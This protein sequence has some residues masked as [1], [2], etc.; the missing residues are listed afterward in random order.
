MSLTRLGASGIVP[1]AKGVFITRPLKKFTPVEITPNPNAVAPPYLENLLSAQHHIITL[2][3]FLALRHQFSS[4]LYFNVATAHGWYLLAPSSFSPLADAAGLQAWR[5]R[6][7]HR[8]LPTSRKGRRRKASQLPSKD[9]ATDFATPISE[10]VEAHTSNTF[11]EEGEDENVDNGCALRTNGPQAGHSM[12]LVTQSP[13]SISEDHL[14]EI[15]DGVMWETP[16]DD[17]LASPEYWKGH[18]ERMQVYEET[19]VNAEQEQFLSMSDSVG[20]VQSFKELTPRERCAQQLLL[21]HALTRKAN[22]RLNVDEGTGLLTLVPIMD[23]KEGDELLLHYGREWWSQ[24]LLSKVFMSVDDKDMHRVRW[25]EALFSKP[26][27]VFTP[28]PLLCSAMSR[29]RKSSRTSDAAGADWDDKNS[30]HT[31]VKKATCGRV[32]SVLY[33]L[34]TRREATDAEVLFS[35]VRR[36]CINRE[37]FEQL[38]GEK[39]VFEVSKCD[40]V[41]PMNQIRHILLRSLR[42]SLEGTEAAPDCTQLL[43]DGLVVG[44]VRDGFTVKSPLVL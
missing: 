4:G 3:R 40:D 25:I 18:K 1:G 23:L 44:D 5:E 33:N 41:V 11:I 27:D 32:K 28:F 10:M 39:G 35:A 24:R 2:R 6:H 16:P 8:Y 21:V 42:G 19:C 13:I 34:A 37:F 36:S 26:T 31:L 7:H 30:P 38:V 43:K 29:R 12:P 22:V 17:D 20:S 14:F 15:N 9:G